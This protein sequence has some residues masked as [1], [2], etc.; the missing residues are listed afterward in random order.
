MIHSSAIERHIVD[1]LQKALAAEIERTRQEL[2][3]DPEGFQE[4]LK[5]FQRRTRLLALRLLEPM[6]I[7][8]T[9]EAKLVLSEGNTRE[10]I[11]SAICLFF[12]LSP[13]DSYAC[14]SQAINAAKMP[15]DDEVETAAIELAQLLLSNWTG[16]FQDLS[17]EGQ[18]GAKAALLKNPPSLGPEV[19]IGCAAYPVSIEDCCAALAAYLIEEDRLQTE[20]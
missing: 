14:I 20:R 2:R 8:L 1:K 12:G 6:R 19:T 18:Q 11:R 4:G 10:E 7:G 17:I 16:L 5:A 9:D 15:R 3:P 13:E